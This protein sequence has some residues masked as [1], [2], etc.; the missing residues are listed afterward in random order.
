MTDA[1]I[2]V[3]HVA[4]GREWRGGQH[5][6]YLLARALS[7][8]P[9]VEQ[10]VVTGRGTELERRLLATGVPVL[11]VSWRWGID[12]R[13][14]LP[15]WREARSTPQSVL[16]AHDAHALALARLVTSRTHCRLVATRRVTFPPRHPKAWSQVDRTLAISNRVRDVLVESG[17][18]AQRIEVVYS[19]IDLEAVA[20]TVPGDIRNEL[21]IPLDS[22]LMVAVGALTPEK[23]HTTLIAA[24]KLLQAEHPDLVWA[25]AGD[26]A[27]AQALLRQIHAAGLERHVFLAG[28]LENPLA[29]IAAADGFVICSV[30]EGLGTSVLDAMA[31]GVPVVGT[32]AGGIPELLEGGAG[33]LI[34]PRDPAALARAVQSLVRE[35]EQRHALRDAADRRVKNFSYVT[36]AN[37]VLAVYRSVLSDR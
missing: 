19:G 30:E 17:L 15:L 4:S 8:V 37:R 7:E 34:P 26:G 24:A 16:H 31:L 23:D 13:V 12:P 10:T 32:R 2:K 36:M 5:Q 20:G 3:I 6:V 28:Y 35:P 21:G 11:A 25:I 9:E 29:L 14:V 27:Q 33:L 22:T 1:T 18:P